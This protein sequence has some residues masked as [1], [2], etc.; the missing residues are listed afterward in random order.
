MSSLLAFNRVY[1]LEIQSVMLVFSTQLCK[2]LP[3]SPF[4]WFNSPSPPCV[5]KYTVYTYTVCKGGRVWVLGLRQIITCRKV[6][7]RVNFF[8]WR[9]F[10]LPSSMSLIFLRLKN[11]QFIMNRTFALV[12]SS[13]QR[14]P[15]SLPVFWI[16]K[17]LLW[18][19][20]QIRISPSVN[21]DVSGSR[22]YLAFFVVIAKICCKIC[23]KYFFVTFSY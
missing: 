12:S 6:P 17:Y 18:I 20:I 13:R 3:L 2:L 16:H 4:L 10:A 22:F 7:L 23:C 8:K 21:F 15:C 5:N 14:A 1:R 9:H 11:T 19:R